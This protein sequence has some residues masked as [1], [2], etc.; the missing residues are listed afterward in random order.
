M[1]TQFTQLT[2]QED[3]QKIE[4]E[5][6]K[7]ITQIRSSEPA[8]LEGIMEQLGNLGESTQRQAG[9]S[10]EILKRPVKDMM[11]GKNNDIPNT[12]LQLRSCVDQLNPTGGVGGFFNKL[13]GKSAISTYI[14]KYESVQTQIDSIINSLLHGRDKLK[15]DNITLKQIK[16]KATENI[17]ELEKRIHFGNRLLTMLEDESKLPENAQRK[18]EFEKGMVKVVSRVKNMTQTIAVLQ[19]SIASTNVISENNEKLDE[20][21]FNAI[22]LTS[23]VVTVS[24]A[25]QLALNNQRKVI[26]AVQ[27][28]NQTIENLITAN[29]RNLKQNTQEIT[30][31]LEKPSIAI[32][33]LKQSMQ[34]IYDAI[35]ISQDSNRR[36][37]DSSKSFITEMSELNNQMQT[38]L[39]MAPT[40]ALPAKSSASSSLLD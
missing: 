9:E 35:Q 12:L 7:V 14:R 31:M 39:G 25:I 36:I 26:E 2:K 23:N 40:G 21:V 20:A 11:D 33:K 22:T 3:L 1:E 28:T 15:E 34:D 16:Q 27:A 17:H 38:K 37:I 10:L 29:A 13:F 32:D 5:A 8:Q 6:G 19:Q 18:A 4:Q 30:T 24:A